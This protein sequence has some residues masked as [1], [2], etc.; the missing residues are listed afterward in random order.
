MTPSVLS[1][2]ALETAAY[3]ESYCNDGGTIFGRRGCGELFYH[4]SYC[5]ESVIMTIYG[6]FLGD[7]S[8][9]GWVMAVYGIWAGHTHIWG[10]HNA[11]G[12]LGD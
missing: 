6:F 4:D 10:R 9:G 2:H 1:H 3:D 5:D 7:V 8:F 11:T 12:F